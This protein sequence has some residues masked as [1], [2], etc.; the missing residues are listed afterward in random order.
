ML[1]GTHWWDT[2]RDPLASYSGGILGILGGIHWLAAL[3]G[4]LAGSTCKLLW[5][6]A[7]RDPLASHSGILGGMLGGIH[8]RAAN[9]KNG[10]IYW[11]AWPAALAGRS[12]GP[13][14]RDTGVH[15]QA[16]LAGYLAG[17]T[18]EQLWR[19]TGW[20]RGVEASQTRVPT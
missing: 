13:L 5:R 3:V 8:W 20:G 12:G 14:W 16:A 4:Y 18:G 1:G 2:R 15:W 17:S 7:R 6:D 11:R 9:K 19:D 10:G